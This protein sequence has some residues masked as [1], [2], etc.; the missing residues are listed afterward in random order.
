[1]KFRQEKYHIFSN[2]SAHKNSCYRNVKVINKHFNQ[3]SLAY[4]YPCRFQQSVSKI[5]PLLCPISLP[6]R[7]ATLGSRESS[8]FLIALVV[9]LL[10][11]SK[12]TSGSHRTPTYVGRINAIP[13]QLGRGKLF[14]QWRESGKSRGS[15]RWVCPMAITNN[16]K[17]YWEGG[18]ELVLDDAGGGL[19]K[20]NNQQDNFRW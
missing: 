8:H 5:S 1:M 2:L 20:A 9:L 19:M 16:C 7:V 6:N 11:R 10:K 14:Q 18:R 15:G 17:I 3:K 12:G 4:F 13:K